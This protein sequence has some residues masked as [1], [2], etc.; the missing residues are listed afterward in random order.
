MDATQN[1]RKAVQAGDLDGA[2]AA[3]QAGADPNHLDGP[4]DESI[5]NTAMWTRDPALRYAMAELLL[6]V[7]ADPNI[8]QEDNLRP[9]VDALR[10]MDTEVA[11]LLLD[12]G[13]NPNLIVDGLGSMYDMAAFNYRLYVWELGGLSA[14]AEADLATEEAWLAFADRMAVK[15]DRRR[16]D[17]L[18]LMRERGARTR[19]E[20][21]MDRFIEFVQGLFEKLMVKVV[22]V[23][24]EGDNAIVLARIAGEPL[25][26]LLDLTRNML[27]PCEKEPIPDNLIGTCRG[28]GVRPYLLDACLAYDKGTTDWVFRGDE[29]LVQ[30]IHGDRLRWQRHLLDGISAEDWVRQA[31]H[32]STLRVRRV[33]C[34]L[35]IEID[36]L[37]ISVPR[38]G[39]PALESPIVDP[40]ELCRSA[41]TD[42][43]CWIFTCSCGSPGCDGFWSGIL[44]VHQ[45]RHTIWRSI[46]QPDAPLAI[47]PRWH[48]RRTVLK[49]V[50]DLL[51]NGPPH[52][53][54]S[55]GPQRPRLEKAYRLARTGQGWFEG[56]ELI[57]QTVV[58]Y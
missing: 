22:D 11:R 49:A 7:G 14:P 6:Q 27:R 37:P 48:Y 9:L 44:V 35:S 57:D 3:L 12:R 34:A 50:R 36:G 40:L 10:F 4:D 42:D 55:W 16:P 53:G 33:G 46:E 25:A 41:V 32:I 29:A 51:R 47:F 1:L 43:E 8:P 26:A 2:R 13:A 54:P 23:V 18:I 20:I 15:H 24:R 58:D 52:I 17:H 56:P 45:G 30:A 39:L 38:E 28:L 21:E 31:G 19:R 5:L